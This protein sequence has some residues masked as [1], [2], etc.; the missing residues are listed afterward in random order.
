MLLGEEDSQKYTFYEK[1]ETKIT[2]RPG[3]I[4]TVKPVNRITGNLET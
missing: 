3:N 1:F 2:G 4:A